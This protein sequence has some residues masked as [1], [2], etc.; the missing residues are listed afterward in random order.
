MFFGLRIQL[1]CFS[2]DMLRV[3]ALAYRVVAPAF[4]AQISLLFIIESAFD[5][6]F[7]PT[8]R[9]FKFFI[10]AFILQCISNFSNANFEI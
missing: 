10:H 2:P 5:S 6:F 7:A 9:A 3:A 8:L 4:F 1:Y